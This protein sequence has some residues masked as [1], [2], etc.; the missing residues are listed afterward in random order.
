MARRVAKTRNSSSPQ[1]CDAAAALNCMDVGKS[2]DARH[3]L[4]PIAENNIRTDWLEYSMLY[5]PLLLAERF[6]TI[7]FH[8]V[9]LVSWRNPEVLWKLPIRLSLCIPEAGHFRSLQKLKDGLITCHH[10][11]IFESLLNHLRSVRRIF[12]CDCF[13][14]TQFEP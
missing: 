10:T 4:W 1:L 5:Q 6:E 14:A 11:Q 7:L 8:D 9:T 3:T 12:D 2:H 13:S